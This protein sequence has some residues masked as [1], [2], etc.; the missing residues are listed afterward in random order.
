MSK[1]KK[2]HY[3]PQYYLKNFAHEDKLYVFDKKI[4]GFIA[5]SRISIKD[6]ATSNYFYN[7]APDDLMRFID[8]NIESEQFVDK[9][10]NEYNE[11]VSAKL[12][13]SF[14]EYGELIANSGIQNIVSYLR[15]DD[16]IDFAM[17]QLF[18]TPFFRV[19]FEFTAKATHQ[20]YVEQKD[21]IANYPIEKLAS[22]MHGIYIIAA[23]CNTQIWK[24]SGREDLIK[25]EFRFIEEEIKD[26]IKQLRS[27][28][29]TL[30]ISMTDEFF[31]TSDNPVILKQNRQG[32]ISWFGIPLTKRVNFTFANIDKIPDL[33]IVRLTEKHR[34]NVIF[35][36][37]VLK[38]QAYRFIYCFD[39]NYSTNEFND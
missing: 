35:Q 3:I 13:D 32:V 25:P 18:R 7:S 17:V 29:K 2:Q 1:N 39:K 30:Q 36:N 8:S 16:I 31:N 20:K 5:N 6:V 15:T 37:R 4:G 23:I 27:L 22:I 12:I 34:R 28:K 21:I 19:Q 11:S 24:Q 14:V 26:K 10:L 9:I 33:Q 38:H